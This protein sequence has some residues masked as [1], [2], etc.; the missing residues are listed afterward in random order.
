MSGKLIFN[1]GTVSSSKSMNLLSVAHNYDT[2]GWSVVTIKPSL[3]TRSRMIETRAQVPP[4]EVDIIL[5]QEDSLFEYT[6]II[7]NADVILVDECQFLS[8]DQVDELREIS[9]TKDID[10]LCF[11][12][13]TDY[14]LHLFDASKRLFELADEINE[15]KTICSIC[16]KK[17]GFNTKTD[18]EASGQI[19][20]PGW[21]NFQ[22]RCFKHHKDN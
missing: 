3:D 20:I 8:S 1:F 4:R 6:S 10:V 18:R 5:K 15:I 22:A 13:R 7:N 11:G 17:A 2:V 16:G 19:V 14:N 9:I 21:D 12:L